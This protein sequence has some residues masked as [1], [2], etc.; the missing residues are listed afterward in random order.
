MKRVRC[1]DCGMSL[2]FLPGDLMVKCHMCGKK[3]WITE[4]TIIPSIEDYYDAS[5]Y[6]CDCNDDVQKD[7]SQ[8][9]IFCNNEKNSKNQFRE[10]FKNNFK[11]GKKNKKVEGPVGVVITIIVII[12]I[13]FLSIIEG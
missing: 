4:E 9:S 13:I 3:T 10:F 2:K 5:D 12:I 8:E 6:Q 11:V 7:D 1:Q